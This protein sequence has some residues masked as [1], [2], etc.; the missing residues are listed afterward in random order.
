MVKL[1]KKYS[2]HFTLASAFLAIVFG[3]LTPRVFE[4]IHFLG[5]LFINLLKVFA[6]PLICTALIASLGDMGNNLAKLKTL[7]RNAVSYMLISEVMAVLIAVTLFNVFKP[8]VGLSPD[9][10]LHGKPA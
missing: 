3:M 10:I 1:L 8:G 7:A 9:L 5:D 4:S 2:T 6:L